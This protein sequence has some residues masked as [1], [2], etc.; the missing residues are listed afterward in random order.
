MSCDK[1]VRIPMREPPFSGYVDCLDGF[2]ALIDTPSCKG[3]KDY[4][5]SG[6]YF[7]YGLNVQAMVDHKLRFC[8]FEVMAPGRCPGYIMFIIR[9]QSFHFLPIG[10]LLRIFEHNFLII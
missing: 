2:L 7:H 4:I 3:I 5:S 1:D 10:L 8:L 6:H 9:Y